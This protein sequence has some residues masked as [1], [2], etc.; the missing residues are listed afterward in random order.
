MLNATD[1]RKT[2]LITIIGL[3]STLVYGQ[4]FETNLTLSPLMTF[5]SNQTTESKPAFGFSGSVQEFHNLS[6][7]FAIGSE[8]NY[9]FENYKLTRDFD[10]TS[11]PEAT[12][13][14]ESKL[15]VNSLK[16]PLILRLKTKSN[17]S[18]SLGY[19][20]TY[21]IHYKASVDYIYSDW[22]SGD[23][24]KTKIP[25]KS[26]DSENDLN[27]YFTIGFGKTFK[28]KD[29]RLL[30]EIYYNKS[31]ADYRITHAGANGTKILYSYDISP[32]SIGFKIGLG[33]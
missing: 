6:D 16:I 33:L 26:V 15:T 12:S 27:T 32:Q 23:E 7:N 10:G 21:N 11:I 28:I 18:L 1:M 22:F 19:G 8:L 24:T 17:W 14:Y 29:L 3:I 20:L 13:Y 31:F 4:S 30:T 5:K 9:S 25:A 2:G